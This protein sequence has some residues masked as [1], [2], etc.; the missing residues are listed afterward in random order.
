MPVW[1][2]R[3]L[4]HGLVVL[5][6]IAGLWFVHHKGEQA[7]NDR[8]NLAEAQ[9]VARQI[10]A[11][12]EAQDRVVALER[13]MQTMVLSLDRQLGTRLRDLRQLETTVI[14]PTLT[15]EIQRETRFT[16]P[17]A[18]ISLGM[19][20]SLNSARSASNPSCVT[21]ANGTTTCSLPAAGSASR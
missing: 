2:M 5:A 3:L 18:G 15:R 12:K 11:D 7:A 14:Q 4:P 20:R 6:V 16:D 17:A 21:D 13:T 8:H 9:A 1:F 10:K 19:L